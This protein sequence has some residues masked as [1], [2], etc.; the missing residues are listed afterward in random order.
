MVEFYS[1]NSS[2]AALKYDRFLYDSS[3]CQLLLCTIHCHV[4]YYY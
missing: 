2:M 3:S 1:L 4:N